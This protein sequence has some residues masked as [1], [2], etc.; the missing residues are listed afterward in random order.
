MQWLGLTPRIKSAQIYLYLAFTLYRGSFS[1]WSTHIIA[2]HTLNEYHALTAIWIDFC[3]ATIKH[4]K[5]LLDSKT[6]N[7]FALAQLLADN[8]DSWLQVCSMFCQ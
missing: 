2:L 8:I 4:G 7:L 1:I 5:V 3:I 6:V